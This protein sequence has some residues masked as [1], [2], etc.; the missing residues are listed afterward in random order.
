[1]AL[2]LKLKISTPEL[3]EAARWRSTSF[4][5]ELT[6]GEL[7]SL[8]DKHGADVLCAR[9]DNGV[10]TGKEYAVDSSGV[11]KPAAPASGKEAATPQTSFN[12]RATWHTPVGI[13]YYPLS[14]AADRIM[15]DKIP[16]AGKSKY[17]YIYKVK[18]PSKRLDVTDAVYNGFIEGV[19]FDLARSGKDFMQVLK[20]SGISDVG[21]G[22][23][24]A[25][26][27]SELYFGQSLVMT[28]EMVNERIKRLFL[29]YAEDQ[30]NIFYNVF[31]GRL[32]RGLTMPSVD[33]DYDTAVH[34][35]V[36]ALADYNDPQMPETGLKD[37]SYE[38]TNY[39]Q[40]PVKAL[41]EAMGVKDLYYKTH[42]LVFK[43]EHTKDPNF[44]AV[45]AGQ[46]QNL[47]TEFL[48]SN[49]AFLNSPMTVPAKKPALTKPPPPKTVAGILKKYG[50]DEENTA[51]S[52]YYVINNF[53]DR[54][55]PKVTKYLLSKGYD[56]L[57]DTKGVGAIHPQERYQGIFLRKAAAQLVGVYLNRFRT[58]RKK[59]TSVDPK[60]IDQK[61]LI[62]LLS[63]K[64]VNKYLDKF[65][66]HIKK[67]PKETDI[68]VEKVLSNS[69]T[70]LTPHLASRIADAYVE[71]TLNIETFALF[72]D[73]F[74]PILPIDQ[75]DEAVGK[76][77][78]SINKNL[79][80]EQIINGRHYL[81]QVLIN[82]FRNFSD[83]DKS[84]RITDATPNL[85]RVVD[86]IEEDKIQKIADD[87]QSYLRYYNVSQIKEAFPATLKRKLPDG[88]P[89]AFATA[90][91]NLVEDSNFK[92]KPIEE[93]MEF[94]EWLFDTYPQAWRDDA[95]IRSC[96]SAMRYT[97][98]EDDVTPEAEEAF[99]QKRRAGFYHKL[100][101]HWEDMQEDPKLINKLV[102]ERAAIN[103]KFGVTTE[104]R[105]KQLNR[106]GSRWSRFR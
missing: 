75:L 94:I 103:K 65:Y 99:I 23:K 18:D 76:I 68:F 16:F 52:C 51:L 17:I 1:M 44:K 77:F 95:A 62:T 81:S 58:G 19:L 49:S 91:S 54:S 38:T 106:I 32:S 37:Y 20:D 63:G 96:L 56:V 45:L 88:E 14:W 102:K 90:V 12:P 24:S 85:K 10:P 35:F 86:A 6:E 57:E 31:F 8:I 55:P 46:F 2:R 13:Y 92:N 48:D 93:R 70:K 74:A 41:L 11:G 43:G 83:G 98:K 53:M 73:Q 89:I 66:D 22:E 97:R 50:M 39:W 5:T 71:S 61:T 3:D 87:L 100:L 40:P 25:A 72:I 59:G 21:G 69:N 60:D 78:S 64:D 42:E 101:V 79:L 104:S 4:N 28:K 9:Y 47:N 82:S 29:H 26:E 67:H 15:A 7:Q 30:Y 34:M 33:A 105:F 80:N 27:I 84:K 36:D